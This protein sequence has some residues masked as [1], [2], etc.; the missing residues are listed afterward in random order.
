[1]VGF[2]TKNF[3]KENRISLRT[4]RLV[5][6]VVPAELA[7]TFN[8]MEEF[9]EICC[10]SVFL[11]GYSDCCVFLI[12]TRAIRKFQRICGRIAKSKTNQDRGGKKDI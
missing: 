1:V 10:G 11:K 4:V 6:F 8:K 9:V 12:I 7:F 5:F 3:L 2:R